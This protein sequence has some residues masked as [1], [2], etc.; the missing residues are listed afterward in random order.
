[1]LVLALILSTLAGATGLPPP[2]INHKDNYIKEKISALSYQHQDNLVRCDNNMITANVTA[3]SGITTDTYNN[4]IDVKYVTINT[5]KA[6]DVY[7]PRLFAKDKIGW[8]S[9]Y[10]NLI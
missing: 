4:Q 6:T 3:T 10:K 9:S 1:M 5:S 7:L 2:K 8:Q